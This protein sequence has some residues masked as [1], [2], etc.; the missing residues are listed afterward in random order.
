MPTNFVTRSRSVPS[1]PASISPA[2]TPQR[3]GASTAMRSSRSRSWYRSCCCRCWGETSIPSD[4]TTLWGGFM[5]SLSSQ[6]DPV[7]VQEEP[8]AVVQHRR[9]FLA[10]ASVAMFGVGRRKFLHRAPVGSRRL[11]EQ[12]DGHQVNR[13]GIAHRRRRHLIAWVDGDLLRG[14]KVFAKRVLV[15][16]QQIVERSAGQFRRSL[17]LIKANHGGQRFPFFTGVESRR[18]TH[19]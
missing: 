4:H 14:E 5:S 19:V 17:Q 2:T 8:H 15:V 18:S 13:V 1:A 10:I 6:L 9:S 11:A 3:Y 16:V 12:G 7:F